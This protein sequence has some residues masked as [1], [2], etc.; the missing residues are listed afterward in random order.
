MDLFAGQ[1]GFCERPRALCVYACVPAI[2]VSL[3]T[4]R[5]Y[6]VSGVS[7]VDI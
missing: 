4:P 1:S 7:A 5:W 6:L 2:E 3:L